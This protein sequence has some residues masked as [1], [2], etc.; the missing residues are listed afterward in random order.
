MFTENYTLNI[1]FRFFMKTVVDHLYVFTEEYI[2]EDFLRDFTQFHS[3]LNFLPYSN[4]ISGSIIVRRLF[5]VNNA[6]LM[7][8]LL[9][10]LHKT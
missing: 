4:V 6:G 8:L 5:Q 7:S 9:M 2:M 10:I 1:L 3:I